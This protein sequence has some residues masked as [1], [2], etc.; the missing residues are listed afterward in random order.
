MRRVLEYVLAM[1][2]AKSL[3]LAGKLPTRE[4]GPCWKIS[5]WTIILRLTTHHVSIASS[6]PS[7][8]PKQELTL[9]FVQYCIHM[10]IAA[11]GEWG[12]RRNLDRHARF[13]KESASLLSRR[14][15]YS[16]V[17]TAMRMQSQIFRDLQ[18]A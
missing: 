5:H 7:A 8:R 6:G 1:H 4:I 11:M 3:D 14:L 12:S 18:S 13:G 10:Y 17:N 9:R 15:P 16:S 2:H